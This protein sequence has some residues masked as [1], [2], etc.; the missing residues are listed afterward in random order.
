MEPIARL[1]QEAARLRRRRQAWRGAFTGLLVASVLCGLVLLLW[2]LLPLPLWT[3]LAAVAV[4]P[5]GVLAGAAAG[6]WRK[7]GELEIARWLDRTLQLE[8]RLST[9]WEWR[10]Q[11]HPLRQL[12]CA[13]AARHA[14]ECPPERLP[15]HLPLTIPRHGRWALLSLGLAAALSFLP[16]YR[17][18][19]REQAA[20]DKAN[21]AETGR[22]LMEIAKHQMKVNP[23]ALPPT[24]KALEAVGELGSQW[25]KV[26]PTRNEAIQDAVKLAAEL[27]KQA[28]ELEKNPGLKKL[29]KAAREGAFQSASDPAALQRK[30]E[31]LQNKLGAAAGQGEKL[32]DLQKRLEK[33]RAAAEK[34]AQAQGEDAEAA[35]QQLAEALSALQQ[36]A[37]QLGQ[38]LEG[39]DAALKALN[40]SKP[41]QVLKN[42]DLALQD[43][44]QLRE[45]AEKLKQAQKELA[46]ALGKN[47]AEQLDRGQAQAAIRTLEQW[48][49]QLLSAQPSPEQLQQMMDDLRQALKP[50]Q[51]YGQLQEKLARALQHLQQGR[52]EQAAQCLGE[53]IQELEDLLKQLQDAEALGECLQALLRA[54]RAI[55]QGQCLG[56]CQGKQGGASKGIRPNAKGVGDWTDQGWDPNDLVLE[57]VADNSGIQRPDKNARGHTER[58]VEKPDQLDP[59]KIQGKITPGQPMPSVTLKGVSI[60]GTSKVEFEEAAAAAQAEAQNAIN[61][62]RV[63]RAYRQQ[64]KEYFDELK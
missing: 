22:R 48:K 54:E 24:Q 37:L 35:R 11:E 40:E 16:E 52:R 17:S 59:T 39:L 57:E 9:A 5:A 1:L 63:P 32:Q 41:G 51:D 36:E 44:A 21:I 45:L 53:A 64:V 34:L 43:L 6:A 31:E 62:E 58:A 8:E 2:K 30:V 20:L 46:Q 60:K 38:N 56:Q 14:A 33:A 7:P 23:P 25:N 27:Q 42:L 12:L 29:E 47:L 15:Q 18:P 61:Q 19:A 49:Q 3:P 28:S 50:A 55:A 4:L 26:P 13:D 10:Q